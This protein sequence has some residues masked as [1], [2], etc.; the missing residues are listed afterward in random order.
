MTSTRD[1]EILYRK[2]QSV[3]EYL[4][5]LGDYGTRTI[6]DLTEIGDNLIE[7]NMFLTKR[8]IFEN[9][10]F[11]IFMLLKSPNLNDRPLYCTQKIATITNEIIKKYFHEES[12]FSR[13]IN[14]STFIQT[15]WEAFRHADYFKDSMDYKIK[16]FHSK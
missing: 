11:D 3:I 13:K 10:L 8:K 12:N 5:T 15:T 14:F 2:I 9:L 1:R 7:Q 16:L 4:E 6:E